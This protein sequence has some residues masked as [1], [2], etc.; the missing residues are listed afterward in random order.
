MSSTMT[1]EERIVRLE[2]ATERLISILDN[3]KVQMKEQ[4]DIN[5]KFHE[6]IKE[7]AKRK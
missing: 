3:L 4:Q 1:L 7:I 6:A 2:D 5:S